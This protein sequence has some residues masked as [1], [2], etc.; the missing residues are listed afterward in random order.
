MSAG[1]TISGQDGIIKLNGTSE[2]PMLTGWSFSATAAINTM[3]TKVMK[4]NNDG[5]ST[6]A[7]GFVKKTVGDKSA[8]FDATFQWQ[9]DDT[10]GAAGILRT[11]DVGTLVTFS[12]YPNLST[13]GSRVIS[14][15]ALVAT[16][17]PSAEVEGV[18]TQSVSFEVDGAW[19]DGVV[20]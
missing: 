13:S 9:K 7:G 6:A 3:S 12:L 20:A 1:S 4:S 14:G 18:V 17:S 19:S 2:I 8:T 15:S 16:V 5:G 10:A 11:D